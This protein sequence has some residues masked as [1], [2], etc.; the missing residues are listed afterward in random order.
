MSRCCNIL[1]FLPSKNVLFVPLLQH[2]QLVPLSWRTICPVVTTYSTCPPLMTYHMSRCCNIL[3]LFPRLITCCLSRY[4][5]I[6][7][8]FPSH[9]VLFDPLLQHNQL[10][11]LS[12]R[13]VLSRCSNILNL[14][15]SP[16]MPMDF[17]L[18]LYNAC[19]Q[20]SLWVSLLLYSFTTFLIPHVLDASGAT[21]VI[22]LC[23]FF[24]KMLG[25]N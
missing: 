4:C 24:Y 17:E 25:V 22:Q 7:N 10:A 14:S 12:S 19:N 18:S 20:F 13:A 3:N 8:L 1:N 15:P 16:D 23:G 5:N 9:D 21:F 6:L 11:P 2:N